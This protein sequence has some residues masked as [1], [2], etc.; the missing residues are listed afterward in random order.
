VCCKL[1][2][3]HRADPISA[4]ATF[5]NQHFR[6]FSY[7][8]PNIGLTDQTSCHFPVPIKVDNRVIEIPAN[9]SPLCPR[10]NFR[11]AWVQAL[12]VDD[13]LF[14]DVTI[15]L[16]STS[17][18]ADDFRFVEPYVRK[19]QGGDDHLRALAGSYVRLLARRISK[20]QR[21][22]EH[23]NAQAHVRRSQRRGQRLS[24]SG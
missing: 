18:V 5:G 19:Q 9:T 23:R 17:V 1:R 21:L 10:L 7:R 11:Q 6:Q 22:G 20:E 14:G 8:T 13:P 16:R 15:I 3:E 4:Y 2:L 24:G 12:P